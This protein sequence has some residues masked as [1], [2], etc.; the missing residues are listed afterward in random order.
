MAPAMRVA[1]QVAR[2]LLVQHSGRSPIQP[3]NAALIAR[4]PGSADKSSTCGGLEALAVE[5]ELGQRNADDAVD[6][7]GHAGARSEVQR[8]VGESMDGLNAIA[9]G[10]VHAP[11]LPRREPYDDVVVGAQS[12][13]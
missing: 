9:F 10:S 7:G 3:M 13:G 6:R 5:I 12:I 2:D 4:A 1:L 11:S 8:V